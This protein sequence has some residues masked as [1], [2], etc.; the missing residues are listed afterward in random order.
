MCHLYDFRAKVAKLADLSSATPCIPAVL[1]K[2]K[3]CLLLTS[4][5]M[6]V[7]INAKWPAWMLWWQNLWLPLAYGSLN[8]PSATLQ[9]YWRSGFSQHLFPGSWTGPWTDMSET[10]SLFPQVSSETLSKTSPPH[11]Q[12]KTS[13][14]T[15]PFAR[16]YSV[17][18]CSDQE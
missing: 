5:L 7:W 14:I 2:S 11:P 1:G 8:G 6:C 10:H 3:Q 15:K 18:L 16:T 13:L 12:K 9:F 4:A 17:Y